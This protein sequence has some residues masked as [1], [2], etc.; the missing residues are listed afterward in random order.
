M[1]QLTSYEAG[2]SVDVEKLVN[3]LGNSYSKL[4][5]ND[6]PIASFPSVMLWGFKK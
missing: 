4:I 2:A 3:L 1:K 6:K 5:N